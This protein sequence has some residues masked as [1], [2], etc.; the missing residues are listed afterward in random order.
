MKQTKKQ[1][2]KKRT[3]K[4][5]EKAVRT[6]WMAPEPEVDNSLDIHP[7][8][9]KQQQKRK[10]LSINQ[11]IK[12]TN[13]QTNKRTNEQTNKRTN[14]QTIKQTK[15]YGPRGWHQNLRWIILLTSTLCN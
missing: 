13:S 10:K 9:L 3:N 11:S 7:L 8:Q 12:Q 6:T 4:Q 15:L 5:T 2:I 14:E 1:T